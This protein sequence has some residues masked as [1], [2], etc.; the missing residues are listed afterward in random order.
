MTKWETSGALLGKEYGQQGR[1]ADILLPHL[2]H[3]AVVRPLLT[4]TSC[5]IT[6]SQDLT[7]GGL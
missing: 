1:K 4:F 7:Y 3:T 2:T 5:Y 6:I